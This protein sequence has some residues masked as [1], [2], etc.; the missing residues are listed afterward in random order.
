[1]CIW[2]WRCGAAWVLGEAEA[3]PQARRG[4]SRDHRPDCKQ[5]IE[6]AI[7]PILVDLLIAELKQIAKRRAAIPIFGNVQLARRLAEA[8]RHQH[9]RHLRP[10]NAL[11]TNRQ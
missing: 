4:Y 5:V 11:L 8:R 10:G 2:R 9:R 7:Q 1:M 3:N 6:A